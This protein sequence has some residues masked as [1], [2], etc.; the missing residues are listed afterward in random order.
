M[1][2]FYKQGL[3]RPYN[4]PSPIPSMFPR[5]SKHID[6][7]AVRYKGLKRAQELSKGQ[8]T[9]LCKSPANAPKEW[10]LVSEADV[11]RGS[12][13]SRRDRNIG[14]A[15]RG[16]KNTTTV[17]TSCLKLSLVVHDASSR[18]GMASVSNMK[19]RPTTSSG[20]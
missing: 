2:W 10:A 4:K 9:S 19:D 7:I 1:H 5:A 6:G 18:T 14:Q 20:T 8:P 17:A 16:N 15:L 13:Q 12:G 11:A 3:T